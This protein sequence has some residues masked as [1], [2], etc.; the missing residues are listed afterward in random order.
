MVVSRNLVTMKVVVDWEE[1]EV[2]KVREVVVRRN[3]S[4]LVLANAVKVVTG[5][6][7]P[8]EV[9]VDEE[10]ARAT[11]KKVT[12]ETSSAPLPSGTFEYSIKIRTLTGKVVVLGVDAD[13]TI[14][15]LK[16]LI[17]DKEGIPP[18][19][20]R[21]I[22]AGAQL[23]DE[24][25]LRAAGV[26]KDSTLHLVLRLRGGCFTKDTMV[27]TAG[28]E[29]PISKVRVGDQ[30]LS[31]DDDGTIHPALVLAVT[32]KPHFELIEVGFESGGHV[33]CTPDHPLFVEDKGWRSYD[34]GGFSEGDSLVGLE[35]AVAIRSVRAFVT[36]APTDVYTLCVEG[37]HCFFAGGVLSHNLN[38]FVKTNEGH[39]VPVSVPSGG[40]TVEDLKVCIL[41]AIDETGVPCHFEMVGTGRMDEMRVIYAGKQLED[42]RSLEAYNIR[43]G[44]TLHLVKRLCGGGDGA[45]YAE[46][47]STLQGMSR[48]RF[49][50]AK[51]FEL[52]NSKATTLRLRL[53]CKKSLGTVRQEPVMPLDEA[54]R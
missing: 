30:V 46:G 42:G 10:N 43:E 23:E 3:A 29:V 45:S 51:A 18:D 14:A 50:S 53:V 16:R 28:G 1:D 24:T 49:S 13:F 9:T 33:T 8:V 2:A 12:K 52:D 32:R 39:T 7:G 37:S 17:Q 25:T 27:A 41:D 19:Q 44:A 22:F 4:P 15:T 35:G 26:E 5:E 54:E 34:K 6:P 48:Q 38:L 21:L 36:E 40:V 47:A 20:Q 11:A 31:R